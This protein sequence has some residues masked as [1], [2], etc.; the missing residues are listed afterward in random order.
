MKGWYGNKYGHSLASKGIRILNK[1]KFGTIGSF[2]NFMIEKLKNNNEINLIDIKN[3]LEWIFEDRTGNKL[4]ITMYSDLNND[5]N[6]QQ[7]YAIPTGKGLGTKV[8]NILKEYADENG[9]TLYANE[10]ENPD[11]C[12][13]TGFTE[14]EYEEDFEPIYE[15]EV[16][17]FTYW[18]YRGSDF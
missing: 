6:L 10:V 18:E 9:K 4:F 1:E 11:W 16:K 12:I 8:V 14:I 7:I 17:D 5:I 3:H 15:G 2:E 13:K